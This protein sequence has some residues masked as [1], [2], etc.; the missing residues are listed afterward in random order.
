MGNPGPGTYQ[1]EN[2]SIVYKKEPTW[3]IGTSSREDVIKKVKREGIPGPG[4]YSIYSRAVE[5]RKY[6]FGTEKRN[7][8]DKGFTPGPGQYHIPCSIVDVPRY[9]TYSSG[10]KDEFRFI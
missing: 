2:V 9:Q 4:N 8:N 6:G 7:A 3:R 5:G 10:F 1:N